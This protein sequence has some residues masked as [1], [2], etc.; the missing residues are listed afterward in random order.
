MVKKYFVIAFL[1]LMVF[2]P[3]IFAEERETVTARVEDGK[4]LVTYSIP[5]GYHQTLQED[6]FYID[7][8]PYPGLQFSDTIY[9]EGH[10]DADGNTEYKGNTTLVK[11]FTVTGGFEPGQ[12]TIYAGYQFCEDSGAC[13]FPEE[14]EIN[15]AIDETA[16]PAAEP[17]PATSFP[18]TLQYLLMA[19]LG[20]I[21]LNVMPCVLPVLSIKAMSLVKQSQQDRKHIFQG[22]MAYTLGILFSFIVLAAII[23]ILKTTGESVGWGFQFQS[24]GFVMALL[25][26]IFV[27]ALSLFDVFIIRAPG[28]QVATK[29]SSKGGLTGSFLSGIFAVLLATPCTAPLLGAALGFAFS[30]PPLMILAIFLLIGLGLAF[31]FIIIGIWP[32]AIRIIPKP[33]EW[34]NIFKEV[35]GFLLLATAFYL[36]RSLYF[37]VGGKELLSVLVYLLI[38]AFAAWIYGRF[39][40][41]EFSKTKQWIATILA[42]VIAVGGGFL[43]LDFSEENITASLEEESHLRPGWEKFSPELLQ[44]YREAGQPVFIDFGAEWCLTCKTN[45]TTVLFTEDIETAFQEKGIKLLKGDNTKKNP[46]IGEWLSRFN[47]AGVPLYIFY[48]P[49]Q[50]EP[51]VLPELITKDMIYNILEKL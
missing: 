47:R 41:P 49:G 21:I 20:G 40:K 25:I 4:I 15:L 5:E 31:P 26:V 30:Q 44:K 37:L 32:K 7:V 8:E 24:P 27:F 13:L 50:E 2:V 46:V 51:I 39:A 9:P 19:F 1:I 36:I 45:E 10:L 23:I 11:K 3:Q 35:M 22:S 29:A 43:T 28:M 12:I 18:K 34:M 38:L 16:L 33:G 17:K 14:K 48:L 6:Y 42:I